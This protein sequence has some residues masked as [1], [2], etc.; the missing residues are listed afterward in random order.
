LQK[1]IRVLGVFFIVLAVILVF[2]LSYLQVFGQKGLE[3][4]AANTRRLIREYGI[5][6]GRI[7]TADQSVAA[8]SLPADGPFEYTR[9]YPLGTLLSH[10]VGYDSPQYG[11]YGLE[12]EYNEFL[13]GR[14]PKRGWVGEMTKPKEEGFD[15]YITIDTGVQAAAAQALGQRKGAVVAMDPKTGAV[16]AAYSWPGFDPNALVSQTRDAKGALTSE[17]V[18]SSYSQDPLS[19]LLNRV[20]M[21]LYTPGSSF[22]VLTASGGIESGFPPDTVYNCPGI[23]EVGGSRVV[24]YGDPPRDFGDIDMDTALTYSVNTYFAQ[25]AYNMGSRRLVDYSELFGLNGMIPL[26]YPS[27]APSRIPPA[28]DMDAV[29]LSWTGAGQGELLLTPLQLCLIG[30]GV[31]NQGDIMVPHL[32]KEVR[33][34]EEILDR[35]DTSVW[36]TPISGSTATDVLEMMKH[37]VQEG[38]GTAAAIPGVSVAGKTGTAEVEGK[39]PHAWFLGIAPAG[40]PQ[41]V[42]AVLVEN[43][44][45]GGG[46]VAAPIAKAVMEAA[47]E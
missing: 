12:E 28:K 13:L 16:L 47:L 24:N 20:T 39:P 43:S 36:S 34:G 26:D 4:N 9:S 29:E 45:G 46:S 18:M 30:C 37:V 3:D 27:I 23:W 17:A 38:T 8:E 33:S 7:I 22:K 2:N 41:V 11:R 32:M 42:V 10:I 5:A 1:S 40:N 14:E 35:Y 21:G 6:R 44:G 15:L 25:L 31:A 19:P